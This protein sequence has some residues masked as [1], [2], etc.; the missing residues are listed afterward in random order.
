MNLIAR[1]NLL[2]VQHEELF[3]D[4]LIFYFNNYWDKYEKIIVLNSIDIDEYAILL[5]GCYCDIPVKFNKNNKIICY[6]LGIDKDD[7]KIQ[8]N[9]VVIERKIK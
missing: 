5:K 1:N 4:K 2:S 9:K 3:N 6:I 8:T 7:N